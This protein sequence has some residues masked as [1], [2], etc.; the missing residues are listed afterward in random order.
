MQEARER[1]GYREE[2]A[3]SR[4]VETGKSYKVFCISALDGDET[5][6]SSMF[7]FA[8]GT[9]IFKGAGVAQSV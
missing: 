4:P 8:P 6:F 3:L 9:V 5:S 2:R 7:H 1:R